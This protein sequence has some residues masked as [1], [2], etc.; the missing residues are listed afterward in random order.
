MLAAL[1]RE[2]MPGA[3][4][5]EPQAGLFIWLQL[6]NHLDAE[7]LFEH[8][9]R[10]ERLAFVPESAFSSENGSRINGARLNYSSP[11]LEAIDEGIARLAGAVSTYGR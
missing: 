3:A 1:R 10:Q 4:W 8:A 2:K 7:G 9:L 5:K 6:A 11:S